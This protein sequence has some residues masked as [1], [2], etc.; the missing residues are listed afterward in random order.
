MTAQTRESL[1]DATA[2]LITA[3][4]TVNLSDVAGLAGVSRQTVYNEF[5]GRDRLLAALA[6]REGR[7]VL[8]EVVRAAREAP[9]DLGDAMCASTIV[10][11]R[12]ASDDPLV[13]AG[14]VGA[15]AP[16]LPYVTNGAGA[17]LTLLRDGCVEVLLERWPQL[18]PAET[19]WAM[20]MGVRLALSH[21]VLQTEPIEVTA[22]HTAIVMR[23][24]LG[25]TEKQAARST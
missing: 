13:K 17:L 10:G 12:A 2:G 9:G 1:L 22:A 14:L 25:P 3:G 8:A 5:G 19:R 7:R 16:L 11:L 6:L 18:D 15:S 24:L 4:R 23:R 20:E 21:I